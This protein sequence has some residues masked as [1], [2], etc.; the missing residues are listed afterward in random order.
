TN[1]KSILDIGTGSGI[2]ALMMAQKTD[3]K[4]EAIDIDYDSIQ[5]A[6][7]NFKN[8][9]WIDNLVAIHSPLTDFVKQSKKKYNLILSNPPYFN[10]SLKS[11]SDR[12]NL[13]KHA[14]TLTHEELLSGVKK[15]ISSNG[16]FTV[17]IPYDLMSSFK[18]TALI[19]GL[20]C[21]KKLI[22]YPT[23]KKPANRTLMEFSLNRPSHLNEDE[24]I[25]RNDSGNF[26]EEYKIFTRDF[27]LDF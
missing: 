22:I 9:P 13:S 11:L 27:Y 2:I 23:P 15:L 17:I 25:I 6:K 26:T 3:V 24:L 21:N 14:S 19:E 20:Y 10:N 8:S 18:N 16:I 4:I 5:E 12:K 7:M 1:Q